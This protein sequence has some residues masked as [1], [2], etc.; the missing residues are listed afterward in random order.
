MSQPQILMTGPLLDELGL[1]VDEEF[2][3]HRYFKAEDREAFL[4]EIGPSCTGMCHSAPGPTIDAAFLDMMPNLKLIA[5]FGVGYDSV[6]AAEAGRRG[7]IV[8]NT[9]DVLNE[10]VADTAVGL[11]LMTVR[12]LGSAEKWLRQGNWASRGNYRLTPLTLR[13]RTL[14]IAG[15]GRIGRA[16]ARRC[17]GFGLPISYFGRTTKQDVPYTFYSS[18]KEMAA[19]VDTMI[20]VTPG[21]A[22]TRNMVD[23]DVLRALGPNGV[24]I[25]IARGSVVDEPALIEALRNKEIAAAGL[26]VMWDEPDI[27]PE[28][29]TLEN[30][31]LLP[32]V[33][34][35]SVHTRNAMGNLV[36]DNL[37]TMAAGEP[38]LTPVPETP[39][40]GW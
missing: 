40:K 20:V 34:S 26:D 17:E 2:Q 15:L 3:I 13:G 30:C 1:P 31:V 5:N 25:N 4:S 7:I 23:R 36:L 38:P 18:L 35:A 8:T 19:D 39:F 24:F 10:E 14:G 6:D 16:I 28:L 32:H 21:T 27:N 29:M 37:K 33:G 12:E 22:E 11:L 9:P